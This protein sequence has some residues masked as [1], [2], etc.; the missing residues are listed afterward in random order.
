MKENI[1]KNICFRNAR[2]NY[3]NSHEY[4]KLNNWLKFNNKYIIPKVSSNIRKAILENNIANNIEDNSL[5]EFMNDRCIVLQIGIYEDE[6]VDLIKIYIS[7]LVPFYFIC[8][9]D[10][11]LKTNSIRPSSVP[12]RNFTKENDKYSVMISQISNILETQLD[13][14]FFD[15]KYINIKVPDISFMDFRFGEFSLF[16]AFFTDENAL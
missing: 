16:N 12:K 6:V 2:E 8:V 1:S 10:C 15:D 13:Y 9:I 3:L 7:L 14:S 4:I 11:K 5:I